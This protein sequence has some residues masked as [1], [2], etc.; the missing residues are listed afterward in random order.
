MQGGAYE[1]RHGYRRLFQYF[2]LP[3]LDFYMFIGEVF[4]G[5][6]IVEI[7]DNIF[8]RSPTHLEAA[9]SFII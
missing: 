1:R 9:E 4:L 2:P 3:V 7:T 5:Q 6:I 8:S